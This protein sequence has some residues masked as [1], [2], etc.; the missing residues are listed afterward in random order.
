MSVFLIL[1]LASALGILLLVGRKM[2]LLR[3]GDFSIPTDFEFALE[4][5]DFEQLRSTL[6]KKSRRFGYIA[7][8]IIIR[9][10][11][12]GVHFLK[13]KLTVL[14]RIIVRKFKRRNK[15]ENTEMTAE[16][17]KFLQKITAYKKR[18]RRIKERIKE[19]EGLN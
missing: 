2:V 10:Y 4:V 12:L 3:N 7:L 17:N 13:R 1:F 18:I 5:P 11:V 8:V 15:P 16:E 14:W 6:Q 9:L 19:E